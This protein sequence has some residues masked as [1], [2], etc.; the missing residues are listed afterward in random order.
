M[1]GELQTWAPAKEPPAGVRSDRL[2]VVLCAVGIALL[3][4]LRPALPGN[5]APVDLV[6]AVAIVASLMSVG[7]RGRRVYLPYALPVAI[8]IV[9]GA[10]GA[11]VQGVPGGSGFGLVQDVVLLVWC[12]AIATVGQDP[13]A[14]KAM[15]AT[16]A[17]SSVAWASWLVVTFTSGNL[18]LAGVSARNGGRVSL[19]MGDPNV[20]ANYFFISL[21]VVAMA[22]RP[23]NRMVRIGAY[24][25][26]L[27]AILLTGSN[28]GFI[29]LA[30]GLSTALLLRFVWRHSLAATI[31]VVSLVAVALIVVAPQVHADRLLKAAH[32]SDQRLI[33][34]SIGRASE[35][36]GSRSQ[37]LQ[38]SI[39][40][41]NDGDLLGRGP[42][43]TKPIL[44]QQQAPYVKEA[45]DDYLATL[46]ERGAFGMVGLLLLLAAVG[47]R[48]WLVVS[49]PL[50]PRFSDVVPRP[51]VLFGAVVG[52]GVAAAFYE[53]LHFRHV[54]TLLALVAAIHLGS[55]HASR[56]TADR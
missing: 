44:R 24:A 26:L 56:A 1:S 45:H 28:G 7:Y 20:A 42:A 16:W 10:L 31:S 22:Q 43:A 55:L 19:T 3:P 54:W 53:V 32:T 18:A 41:F 2:P 5:A 12:A 14:L 35:S 33:R 9:G 37:L 40:L 52:C 39:Q 11:L 50:P 30:A 49:T 46:V 47:V 13:R 8:M 38:E 48:T 34:D 15:L 27:T 25:I 51:E 23:R 21:M 4:V 36:E 29:T 6:M 17:W